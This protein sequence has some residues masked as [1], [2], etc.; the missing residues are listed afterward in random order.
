MQAESLHWIVPNLRPQRGL[1]SDCVHTA[2][3]TVETINYSILG[4]SRY[5]FEVL[6]EGAGWE[7]ALGRGEG[8]GAQYVRLFDQSVSDGF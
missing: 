1:H 4:Y 5:R 6:C 7:P 2:F 8:A 3:P